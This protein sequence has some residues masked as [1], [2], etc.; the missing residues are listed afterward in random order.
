MKKKLITSQ[1]VYDA[2]WKG[3][4]LNEIR[5]RRAY[6]K[7]K[8]E[9]EKEAIVSRAQTIMQSGELIPA[10]KGPYGKIARKLMSSLSFMDYATIAV[11]LGSGGY[12]IVRKIME[13]RERRAQ[14]KREQE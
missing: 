3:Y 2:S 13:I 14:K 11:K 6:V 5:Y 9:M 8:L 10:A 7:V 1:P 4:T 12:K